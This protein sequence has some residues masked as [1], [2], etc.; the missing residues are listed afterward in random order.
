[1]TTRA[2]ELPGAVAQP[3]PRAALSVDS[4][5]LLAALA[6]VFTSNTA[7]MVLELVA[8]RIMAPSIGS[9]LYTWTS[10]IG[11]I[12]AGISLGNYL[13]GM[14]ADR[15]ASRR[16]V[17]WAFIAAGLAALTVVPIGAWVASSGFSQGLP[18]IGRIVLLVAV[19]FFIPSVFLGFISPLVVKLTVRNLSTTGHTVG[20]IYG[21][22][23]VGNIVGTFL[24]G[25]FLINWFPT[26]WIV[27]GVSGTL[28]LVGL[29]VGRDR[30]LR[31]APSST[32]AATES[33]AAT[34]A[35]ERA[36]VAAHAIPIDGLAVPLGMLLVF[37]AN[38]SVMS[39]EMVASRVM[40][41]AIGVSLYTW[42]S[43]IGVNLA[44]IAL[45]NWIGGFIADRWASR[46]TAAWVF[47]LAALAAVAVIPVGH[48]VTMRGVP[49]ELPIIARIVVYT[50][51]LFFIPCMMLGMLTPILVKLTLRNLNTT[52]SVVGRIYASGT[53]GS[54]I[55][56]FLTGFWLISAFGTRNIILGIGVTL[57]IIAVLIGLSRRQGGLRLVDGVV[58][59]A[60][61]GVPLILMNNQTR[62]RELQSPWELFNAFPTYRCMTETDYFCIR[63]YDAKVGTPEENVRVLVLDHLIHSYNSLESNLSLKYAYERSYADLMENIPVDGPKRLLALGGGGY[64]FPRYVEA[65][66]PGSDVHVIEIDPGVTDVALNHMGLPPD[67]QIR[68]TNMDARQYLQTNPG[69]RYNFVLGDAFNDYSVPFH[70]TTEEFTQLVYDHLTDDGMYLANI[71]DTNTAGFLSAYARTINQVFPYVYI[72]PNIPAW[73]TNTRS[74]FVIVGSKRPL[75]EYYA[76]L[77]PSGQWMPRAEYEALLRD[78]PPTILTDNYVPTDNLLAPVFAASGF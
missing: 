36:A 53:F 66:Y 17:G 6:I 30:L 55:G 35:A 78:T 3:A 2:D 20:L 54:I 51:A 23:T 52:G 72:I 70:L 4:L 48:W 61:V 73:K 14:V 13:S 59:M 24:T 75:D 29:L 74:T 25:F 18:T 76:V 7:I 56:T 38:V 67:T 27:A 60:L 5:P 47:A 19:V 39:L 57:A 15:I 12:L 41:P 37:L 63:W 26:S 77:G 44:G 64:T 45:G 31:P 58:M 33:A 42:T 46:R 34:A 11:V 9:S 68:T 40:A 50:G 8:S 71:I 1:M 10:I 69:E 43:I 49:T 22:S 21:V 32:P 62:E 65:K 28:I 16:S